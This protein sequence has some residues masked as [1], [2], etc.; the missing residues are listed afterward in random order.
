MF[1]IRNLYIAAIFLAFLFLWTRFYKIDTSLLFFNDIGRDFLTL[2][3][4]QESGKPPLLGPQTSALPF[5]QSAVYFYLLYPFY[6]LTSHSPYASLIACSLFYVLSFFVGLYYLREYPR[7]EKSL[8]LVFLLII[9][10]PQYIIQGRFIWNP[11]FVTPFI[12]TA[13]YSLVVYLEQKKPKNILLILSAFSIA[14]ATAFS[15]ST[16]PTL[17]AFLVLIIFRDRKKFF[18]YFSY[19]VLALFIVNLPTIFFE[20]RHDFL[21]S[22]MMLFGDRI[23]Q[24]NNYLFARL[25]NLSKFS[26]AIDWRIVVIYL[27][28]LILFFYSSLK[29]EKNRFLNAGGLL[30]FLTVFLTALMPIS[31]HSH[32]IFGILPLLFLTI[33]FLRTRYIYMTGVFFYIIF[34][35][36]ALNENYFAKAR[37]TVAELQN[38]AQ[39]FCSKKIGPIFISNQSSHHP[40]HNAMEFQY[41]MS[42][43]G[44]DVR[45]INEGSDQA[46]KMAVI[47]DDDSYNHGKTAFYELTLFGKSTEKERIACKD[48]LEIVLLEK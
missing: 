31:V 15:Y 6:L 35:Q 26:F 9:V 17:L 1:K 42:E 16:V 34:M 39:I 47:L 29:K 41:F 2:W 3:K 37:N 4:W 44:C 45:N 46:S 43:A 13:F 40:Y 33:S 18:P 48:K 14:L 20:L 21:L 36:A 19:I 24:G 28:F 10:H 5:N 38:C 12:L 23:D 7:L 30:L 11:S 32:Y 8:L 25:I 22:K 27:L